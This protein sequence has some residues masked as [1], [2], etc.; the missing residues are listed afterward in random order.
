MDEKNKHCTA[1]D[2]AYHNKYKPFCESLI[3]NCLTRACI[4]KSLIIPPASELKRINNIKDDK[5]RLEEMQYYVLRSNVTISRLEEIAKT[6]K[7]KLYTLFSSHFYPIEYDE[8]K[9]KVL[10]NGVPISLVK[11]LAYTSLYKASKK[12]I[13]MKMIK[14]EK[15]VKEEEV[16]IEK[17][18]KASG[19]K[20]T[21]K[22]RK[23]APT[24]TKKRK[25]KVRTK[26]TKPKRVSKRVIKKDEKRVHKILS[27]III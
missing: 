26:P 22:R 6:G 14:K 12:L 17:E 24:K 20:T 23:K 2:Y 9:K 27:S 16:I 15:K 25:K 21:K 7:G 19:R 18:E 8:K 3:K 13:P 5:K 4:K 10:F 1:F 11:E